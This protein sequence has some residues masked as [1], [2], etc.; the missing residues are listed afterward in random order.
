MS[1]IVDGIKYSNDMKT[2]EG[3]ESKHI[4]SA[5]IAEGV[6]EMSFPMSSNASTGATKPTPVQS[7]VAA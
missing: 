5:V 2:V 6:T 4:T 7:V 1:K 3:V